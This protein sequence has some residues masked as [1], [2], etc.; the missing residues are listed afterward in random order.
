MPRT[1][2]ARAFT[3]IELLVV[4]TIAGILVALLFPAL[5]GAMG[6]A[7][8][9]VCASNLR[10]LGEATRLYLKDHNNQFFPLR[11]I[12][13]DGTLWYYGFE[14][15]ASLSAGEGSRTFDRTRGKLYPY[16]E[17]QT[18]SVEVCPSFYTSGIYKPKYNQQWWTYGINYQLSNYNT[19]RNLEEIRGADASRTLVFA[20]AAQINTWQA[21]ASPG[22]P[23]AEE[24]FY[25]QP[26]VRMVHFR[27]NGLANVLF[28]DW[29]VEALPPAANSYSPLLPAARI[30][31]FDSKDVLFNPAVGK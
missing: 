5:A 3:L 24:W 8:R 15:S 29:H 16:L 27:H 22:R 28:A 14:P 11:T 1:L 25:I 26:S 18:A 4:I 10:Q 20:D 23:M 13:P 17:S 2:N 6:I 7:N 12:Q 9:T 31:Y 30:G 19:G 21:P